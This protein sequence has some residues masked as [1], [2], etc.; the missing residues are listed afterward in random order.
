LNGK[1][2]QMNYHTIQSGN[3][4]HYVFNNKFKYLSGLGSQAC[5]HSLKMEAGVY[6]E[7]RF[8]LLMISRY[9]LLAPRG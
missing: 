2:N 9:Y 8:L 3:V 4:K 7:G 1:K 5:K 6:N